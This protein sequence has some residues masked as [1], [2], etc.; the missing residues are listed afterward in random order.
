M[1]ADAAVSAAPAVS[2]QSS[3]G[4]ITAAQ[5]PPWSRVAR[6]RPCGEK[7]GHGDCT[8]KPGNVSNDLYYAPSVAFLFPRGPFPWPF[9]GP[10]TFGLRIASPPSFYTF[11]RKEPAGFI[12]RGR[13]PARPILDDV[14]QQCFYFGRP[15]RL[16]MKNT[17]AERICCSHVVR[18][19]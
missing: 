6:A 1:N 14:P 11:C 8:K 5:A 13:F 18:I 9:H 3:S 15:A 7:A 16:H 10:P 2:V 17:R 12:Y 4:S 19:A